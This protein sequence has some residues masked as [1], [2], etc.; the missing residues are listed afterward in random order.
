MK[1]T[2]VRIE[3]QDLSPL[4]KAM[5]ERLGGYFE[6]FYNGTFVFVNENYYLRANENLLNIVIVFLIGQSESEVDVISG[7]GSGA[8]EFWGVEVSSNDRIVQMLKD[9]CASNHWNMAEEKA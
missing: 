2:T 8:G 7:G 3:G 5:E 9:I 1:K 6:Y 4:V